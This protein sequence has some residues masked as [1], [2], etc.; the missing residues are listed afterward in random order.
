[1]SVEPVEAPVKPPVELDKAPDKA[2]PAPAS[3][4]FDSD[5][6]SIR[7]ANAAI[8]PALAVNKADFQWGGHYLTDEQQTALEL[9]LTGDSVK[10][11]AGAGAVKTST[12]VAISAAQSDKPG[13]FMRP[14]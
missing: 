6:Y 4:E 11:E 2:T 13:I 12:L 10:I 3:L 5:V 1:M 7:A 8:A 9:A 14:T